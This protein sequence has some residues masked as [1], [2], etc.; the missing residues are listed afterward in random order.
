MKDMVEPLGHHK[1]VQDC[2]ALEVSLLFC[3]FFSVCLPFFLREE[4][5]EEA[6]LLRDIWSRGL[7]FFFV[8][9]MSVFKTF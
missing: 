3:T 9:F 1:P 5:F 4:N 2:C 8:K 6:F 7:R